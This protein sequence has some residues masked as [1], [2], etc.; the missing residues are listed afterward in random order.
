MG[1]RLGGGDVEGQL[2]GRDGEGGQWEG[3]DGRGGQKGR[4]EEG[5]RGGGILHI[6]MM[7]QDAY[8]L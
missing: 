8:R 3:R 6:D 7:G 2:E 1:R 4:G 5:A